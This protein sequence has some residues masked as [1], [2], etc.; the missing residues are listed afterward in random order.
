MHWSSVIAVN[1]DEGNEEPRETYAHLLKYVNKYGE[2][3]PMA[4]YETADGEKFWIDAE[5]MQECIDNKTIPT[6]PV[7]VIT[8]NA[9]I[10]EKLEYG[11]NKL[12]LQSV[13]QQTGL[14][15]PDGIKV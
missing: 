2:F 9:E 6:I 15:I 8:R 4:H 7:E 11:R 5:Y 1:I 14:V 3:G 12:A 13:E 10:Q